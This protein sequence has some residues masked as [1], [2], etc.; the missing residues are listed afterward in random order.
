MVDSHEHW[1]WWGVPERGIQRAQ[2]DY[3]SYQGKQYPAFTSE[4]IPEGALGL[5]IFRTASSARRFEGRHCPPV[6]G[7]LVV[8]K[9]IIDVILSF[10]TESYV[11]FHPVIIMARGVPITHYSWI[12]IQATAFCIDYENLIDAEIRYHN[13]HPFVMEAK[14]FKYKSGCL[15]D[16]HIARDYYHGSHLVVSRA[17]KNALLE[18]GEPID[19]RQPEDIA[20]PWWLC[21]PLG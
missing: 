14:S 13:G 6:T 21:R 20:Q 19:F 2:I 9:V 16:Y 3:D 11:Q 8:D 18:T 10:D 17:L 5:P 15:G 12:F 1:V 7:G 4:R